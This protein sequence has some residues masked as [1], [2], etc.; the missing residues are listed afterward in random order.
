MKPRRDR[1]APWPTRMGHIPPLDQ[2]RLDRYFARV[3]YT[4]PRDLTAETLRAVH[5][6]HLLAIPYENL[7]IH[8]GRAISMDEDA[9]FRKLV[10]DRRGGWCYELNG[11]LSRVL[12]AMGFEVRRV[13]GAVGRALRG[14]AAVDNHLVLIVT[15]DRPW[16]VDT[17]LGDGFLE[18]LPLEPG[19]Y[20]Q[21]FFDYRVT[22]DGDW[23]RVHNHPFGG[24]DTFDFTLAPRALESFAAKCQDLQT[25][26]ESNFVK[27][28][29]CERFEPEGLV[30]LRG[31]VLREV[32]EAGV[33]ETV[34]QDADEYTRVLRD[35]FG[36]AFPE[37][38]HL[39][40]GVWTRHQEWQAT[41]G[42]QASPPSTGTTI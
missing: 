9:M 18:P 33:A 5:R 10:D 21:G 8:L 3:G 29:V 41:Q 1:L 32:R 31:A 17:G 23:W 27:A 2:D 40:P 6:A 28:T 39:W 42:A 37:V 38:A 7:D 14:D 13:G 26:P 11:V 22:S 25:S 19:A 36:L 4:G 20:R 12:H 24:V 30:I 15:L 35:R 16:L 34:I